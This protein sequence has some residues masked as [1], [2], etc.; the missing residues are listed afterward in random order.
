MAPQI[1]LKHVAVQDTAPGARRFFN[2]LAEEPE[3]VAAVLA[4]RL[5]AVQVKMATL[6]HGSCLGLPS[7]RRESRHDDLVQQLE[8]VCAVASGVGAV[9]QI[10]VQL[11]VAMHHY[12]H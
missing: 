6:L 5:R 10:A 2:A 12:L 9:R 3:T 4:P 8:G 7:F 11:A 1:T